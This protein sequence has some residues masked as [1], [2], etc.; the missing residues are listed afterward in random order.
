MSG[1]PKT[2]SMQSLQPALIKLR[3]SPSA[4]GVPH[5]SVGVSCRCNK[6]E[7][8]NVVSTSNFRFAVGSGVGKRV[9]LRVAYIHESVVA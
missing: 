1:K 4:G 8:P 6:F 7:Y 5:E 2:F 3:G 9:I